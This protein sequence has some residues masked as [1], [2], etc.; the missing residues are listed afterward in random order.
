VSVTT[1]E[2]NGGLPGAGLRGDH[3]RPGTR[4]AIPLVRAIE[5]RLRSRLTVMPSRSLVIF[6][7]IT[8]RSRLSRKSSRGDLPPTD[9]EPSSD[10]LRYAEHPDS[11]VLVCFIFDPE[12]RINNPRG[13]EDDL[14]AASSE[15]LRVVAVVAQ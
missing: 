5:G 15:R 10:F 3:S 7:S 1:A 13:L 9:G 12:R 4:T 6:V 2:E 8:M 14:E 11:D